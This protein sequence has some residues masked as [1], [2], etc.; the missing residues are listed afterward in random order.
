MLAFI[1]L[2]GTPGV[3]IDYSD[4]TSLSARPMLKLLPP[5]ASDT[6]ARSVLSFRIKFWMAVFPLNDMAFSS[7]IVCVVPSPHLASSSPT[8]SLSLYFT[9]YE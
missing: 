1:K 8:N 6:Y 9:C 4:M 3:L 2:E 5:P 7:K